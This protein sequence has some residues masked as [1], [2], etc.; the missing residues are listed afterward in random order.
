MRPTCKQIQRCE[1]LVGTGC[2]LQMAMIGFSPRFLQAETLFDALNR[3]IGRDAQAVREAIW[4]G[5]NGVMP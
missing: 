4:D 2:S 1:R 3:A 5:N